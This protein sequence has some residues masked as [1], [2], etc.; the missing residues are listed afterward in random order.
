[1]GLG[2]HGPDLAEGRVFTHGNAS[3]NQA[4]ITGESMPVDKATGD[5]A[6]SASIAC[7][8]FGANPVLWS[9]GT[10]H[11]LP[12]PPVGWVGLDHL[13]LSSPQAGAQLFDVGSGT[14]QQVDVIAAWT[15][16]A[17]PGGV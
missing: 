8:A 4:A 3:I 13:L 14:M 16:G 7:A 15:V 17:I 12:A 10:S 2:N 11:T 9:R 1:M 6:G 5:A